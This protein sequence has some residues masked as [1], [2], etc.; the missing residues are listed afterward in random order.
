MPQNSPLTHLSL[1]SGIGG[2]DLAAEWAGFTTI[3]Q[4]D[5]A[6]YPTKILNKHW[7]DVPKW[8][9]IRHV[10]A[11]DFKTKTGKNTVTLISGGFPCQPFSQAGKRRGS[12]DDRYLWPEMFRV[13]EELRPRWVVGENVAGFVS[14]ALDKALSDLE[15][16]G[17][18]ARAFVFP[19]CAVDAPHQRMRCFV[20]G[21]LR[22]LPDAG[23]ER[24]LQSMQERDLRQAMPVGDSKHDG[25]PAEAV[26]GSTDET[27]NG[28]PQGSK[29]SRQ[30]AGAGGRADHEIMADTDIGG[31]VYGESEISPAKARKYAQRKSAA[32]GTPLADTD[33]AGLQ[34]HGRTGFGFAD[35]GNDV[36]DADCVRRQGSDENQSNHHGR[37]DGKA[38]E[39]GRRSEQGGAVGCGEALSENTE[40]WQWPAEPQLGR[41]ADGVSNRVDR[42]KC[43]GNAVV[44]RQAYQVFKAIAAIEKENSYERQ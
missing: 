40:N 29:T 25:L 41:V 27:R 23:R 6:D 35:C 12:A 9:D 5:N 33:G 8:K 26:A 43:L 20:V 31:F 24:L 38:S 17:Y 3:G 39:Q 10:T 21:A 14:M 34:G 15:S 16:I 36:S 1:F 18:E 32:G 7:P 11:A 13:I 2:L 42:I 44:P 30:S 28:L 4:C 22:E 37:R 19:A